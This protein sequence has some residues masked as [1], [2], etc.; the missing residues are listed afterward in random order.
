VIGLLKFDKSFT[1]MKQKTENRKQKTEN[2]KQKT[3]NRKPK[4]E[5]KRIVYNFYIYTIK[6]LSINI[7]TI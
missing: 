3:E 5:N 7:W 6:F 1:T 4:T 2:R